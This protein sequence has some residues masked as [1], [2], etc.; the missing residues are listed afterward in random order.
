[1]AYNMRHEDGKLRCWAC[2]RV[3]RPWRHYRWCF[4][5]GHRYSRLTLLLADARVHQL[6]GGRWRLRRLAS[7]YVCPCCAHDF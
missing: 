3:Q 2:Y 7:I 4:E 1:M 5:C 6:I